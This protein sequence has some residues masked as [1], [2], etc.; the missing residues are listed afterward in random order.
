MT[1]ARQHNEFHGNRVWGQVLLIAILAAMHPC[2]WASAESFVIRNAKVFD[3][4]N[5][6][7]DTDVQIEGHTIKAI[8]KQLPT[9]TD[10]KVI[11]GAG[12]TLLPGL[13]DA[14]T[15]TFVDDALKD[16]VAFG[17]TTELDMF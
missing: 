8:G 2:A 15:H 12:A 13:I 4:H 10:T 11:D 9:A 3:G 6:L 17:V 1:T 14:H 7:S 16:A 5:L